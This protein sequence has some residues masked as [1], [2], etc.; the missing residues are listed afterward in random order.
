MSYNTRWLE[1]YNEGAFSLFQITLLCN[2]SWGLTRSLRQNQGHSQNYIN[3]GVLNSAGLC[4]VETQIHYLAKY[5]TTKE[6]MHHPVYDYS[7][8]SIKIV[9]R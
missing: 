1:I 9:I 5:M 6:N 3:V 4:L 7:Y 8:Y 2:V